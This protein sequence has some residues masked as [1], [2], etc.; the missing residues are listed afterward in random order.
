MPL[1]VASGEAA[2]IGESQKTEKDGKGTQEGDVLEGSDHMETTVGK[3]SK[4]RKLRKN[5]REI[6][7]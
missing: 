3:S 1:L 4:R 6:L 7:T 2:S 5:I